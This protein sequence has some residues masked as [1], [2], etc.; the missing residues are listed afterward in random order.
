MHYGS[1][2]AG[3]LSQ[4]C[5]QE[6]ISELCVGGWFVLASDSAVVGLARGLIKSCVKIKRFR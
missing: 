4:L 5:M 3:G 6:V 1:L 2:V